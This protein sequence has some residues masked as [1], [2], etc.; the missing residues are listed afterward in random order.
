MAI[1]LFLLGLTLAH[2][3]EFDNRCVSC[4]SWG[5]AYCSH[6]GTAEG[7]CTDWLCD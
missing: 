6:D 2:N 1:V 4:I 3:G 5:F 7:D